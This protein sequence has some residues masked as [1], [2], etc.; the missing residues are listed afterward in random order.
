MSTLPLHD[1]HEKLHASFIDLNGSEAVNHY[2]LPEEEYAAVSEGVGIFDLSFRGRLRVSGAD[3]QRFLN[4]QVTNNVAALKPGEGCYAALVTAKGRMQSDLNI[5]A[6]ADQFL[7]D[8]EPGL[9][10]KVAERLEKFIIAD[11]VQIGDAGPEYGLISLQG[12]A[13]GQTLKELAL[14]SELPAKPLAFQSVQDELGPILVVH[15]A[16]TGKAGFDL[17]ASHDVLRAWFE[18]L[19]PA[20][21]RAGR[22]AVCGWAALE[23]ARI[24]AGIPRFGADMDEANLAPEAGIEGRAV[25]YTKGC[26]IGQE[27][28]A[29][30]RTYGQVAR[31]LKGFILPDTLEAMPPKGERLWLNGKEAGYLTSAVHSPRFQKNIALG[32]LHRDAAKASGTLTMRIAAQETAVR[33]VELPFG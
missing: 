17:F 21:A 13:A 19:R 6:L 24:E 14:P 23:C 18:R 16:R 30:I 31:S 8:F 33:V 1:L 25:S 10:A 12:P 27:V 2:G 22:A 15:S 29:R 7:V 28:I 9:T 20:A 26:Y 11:D 5:Y 32:Y 4:G 3:R